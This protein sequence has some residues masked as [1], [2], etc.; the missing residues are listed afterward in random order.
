MTDLTLRLMQDALDRAVERGDVGGANLLVLQHGRERWYA[1][2]GMRSATRGEAMSRDTIVRL[3][4]QTKPITAVAAMILVERGLLDLGEPV[5][6]Y[7][8]GFAGQHVGVRQP[9]QVRSGIPTETGGNGWLLPGDGT[10][11]GE[12]VQREMRI[13]D[14][15]TM[16]SGLVYGESTSEAGRLTGALF[17]E[18]V[19]R[20]HGGNPIGTVEFANRLGRLPLA[21]QPGSHF[22]Y[23][24]SADVLGAVIEVAAGRR[25]GDVIRDEI[26]EPLGMYDTAFFIP[27]SKL[28]RL[29]AIY[30]NP[31]NPMNPANAGQPLREIATDHLGV[32]YAAT[33]DPVFQSGGAGLYSTLD[34]YARFARMMLNGGELDGV[35]ILHGATVAA[36][37]SNALEPDQFADLRDWKP[38]CGYNCFMR[39]VRDPGSSEIIGRIG[40]YGW[41][42]WLGTRW[43]NSPATDSVVLFQTQLTNAGVIPLTRR[44]ANIA[45]CGL[46]A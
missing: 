3:Y 46:E 2:A 18:V 4:S 29:A 41:D 22:K 15:L 13:K 32:A 31:A 12:P 40:E 9:Q 35:R 42:G 6:A 28:G 20:L 17:D 38:G 8:P 11:A 16:R 43:A 37:T 1:G 19:S 5:S 10:A 25:L 24:T 36:M 39:I 45:A 27:E 30:D 44:L 33:D 21:F 34:D 14:L 7:L 26:C 23:G